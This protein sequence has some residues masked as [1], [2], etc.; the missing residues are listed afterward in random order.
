MPSHPT[1]DITGTMMVERVLRVFVVAA[2][3]TTALDAATPPAHIAF[4]NKGEVWMVSVGLSKLQQQTRTGAKVEDF[5]FSPRGDYLA[6]A[7]RLRPGHGRPICSI[8]IVN[9]AT[10]RVIKE[11]QPNDG[12]IDIDKWLG[13]TLVYHA[14]AAMEISG[15]F[16]FDAVRLTGREL[17]SHAG[18]RALDSD[19]TP[20]GSL[21]AYVD[22]VG[23]GP[24]FEEQ[25]HLVD[26]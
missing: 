17:E 6:Y 2:L 12:W 16:E 26:M 10:G 22:N 25:L 24:T 7:E 4:L 3:L 11:L 14:S 13:T 8:V 19:M 20:D 5:R 18:S 1:T 21:L 9:L 23:L 15:V